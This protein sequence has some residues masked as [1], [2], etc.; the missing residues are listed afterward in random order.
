[1][2]LES[3]ASLE[4]LEA[5]LVIESIDDIYTDEMGEMEKNTTGL[6]AITMAC[7]AREEGK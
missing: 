4:G 2:Q 6:A 1:M 3:E 5:E 7:R